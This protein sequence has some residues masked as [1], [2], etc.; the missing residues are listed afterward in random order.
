[1][2]EARFFYGFIVVSVILLFFVAKNEVALKK[3]CYAKGGVVIEHQCVKL[4]KL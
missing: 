4:E 3:E 2:T 1:M